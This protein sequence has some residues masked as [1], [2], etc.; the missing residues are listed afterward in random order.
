LLKKALPLLKRNIKGSKILMRGVQEYCTFIDKAINMRL[1]YP[2]MEV[3]F[4]K[5]KNVDD[6]YRYIATIVPFWV[7]QEK[8][9]KSASIEWIGHPSAVNLIDEAAISTLQSSFHYVQTHLRRNGD[10]VNTSELVGVRCP[11]SGACAV[12]IANDYPLECLT[13]PW[14]VK[15]KLSDHEEGNVCFYNSGVGS[16]FLEG[17]E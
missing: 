11:F 2:F 13:T 7:C 16:L 1:K 3:N 6:F 15:L 17:G 5:I 9:D 8:A 10:I 14:D 12:Q 4:L